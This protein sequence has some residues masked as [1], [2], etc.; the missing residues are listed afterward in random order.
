[1]KEF[2]RDNGKIRDCLSN[3]AKMNIFE[4][5]WYEKSMILRIFL[6][7]F[8]NIGEGLIKIIQGILILIII[9]SLPI[10]FPIGA[11][12][13]IRKAKKEMKLKNKFPQDRRQ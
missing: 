2:I 1:M 12:I 11:Y 6:E 10:T 7:V 9:I 8:Q 13:I 5:M 3:K 4:W